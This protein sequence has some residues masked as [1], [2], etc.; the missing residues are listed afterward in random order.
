MSAVLSIGRE[1]VI[2]SLPSVFKRLGVNIAGVHL[3][4]VKPN[5]CGYYPPSPQLMGALIHL[6]STCSEKVIIGDTDS[7]VHRVED[8]FQRRRYDVFAGGKVE[9]RNLLLDKVCVMRVPSPHAASELPIPEAAIECDA[10]INVPGLGTHGNTLL[11]CASKNL[12]GL[13]ASRRKLT[14]FHPLGVDEVIA[15]ICKVI[16]P[17]VNIVDARDKIL[18]GR[19]ILAVDIKAAELIGLDP[20]RVKHLRLMALDRGLSLDSITVEALKY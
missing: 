15:D 7:A 16:K 9:L 13:I 18:I 5:L 20:L 11:T 17:T 8:M 14:D 12:F 10:L 19:D 3:A 2:D 6:L 1:R 4:L